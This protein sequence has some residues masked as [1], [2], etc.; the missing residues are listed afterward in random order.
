MHTPL[1]QDTAS[2]ADVRVQPGGE[3]TENTYDDVRPRGSS[4][5]T[6]GGGSASGDDSGYGEASGWSQHRSKQLTDQLEGII[7]HP[8]SIAGTL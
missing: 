4:L 8:T 2:A 3:A 7:I 5:S 1:S 6:G